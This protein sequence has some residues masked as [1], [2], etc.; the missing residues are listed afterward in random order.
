LAPVSHDSRFSG[1]DFAEL[2]GFSIMRRKA[3]E[4]TI[5]ERDAE[6]EGMDEGRRVYEGGEE[7]THHRH[8]V[9][10]LSDG[11]HLWDKN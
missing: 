9:P 6:G 10:K 3:P 1:L 7:D 5:G 4:V 11:S 8:M 2:M